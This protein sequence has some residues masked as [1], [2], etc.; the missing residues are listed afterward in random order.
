MSGTATSLAAWAHALTPTD[1]DLRLADRALIDTVAVTVAGRDHPVAEVA[2]QLSEAGRL[3]TVGHVVDFDDLHMESTSHVSVVCVPTALVAGGGARTYL[4][5][6][7]VMARVGTA[8]GWGHYSSGW[9]VTCTAGALGAAA[10]A[11]SA[12]GLGLEGIAT[13]IAL[14]VPGAG[15]VQRAFGTHAKSLQVGF[16]VETGLR[17]AKLAAA[18]ATCDPSAVDA[19]MELVGAADA[20]SM[21]G[22]AVPGGLAIKL[23][24]CCY[25]LQR[26]ISAITSLREQIGA[27][28]EVT[29]IVLSTPESTI[30]PLIHHRPTTGLQA[31]FSLEYAVATALLDDYSGSASFEDAAVRRPEAR[32]IMERVEIRTTPGGGGLLSGELTVEL[33]RSGG[34]IVAGTIADPPGSPNRPPADDQLAAKLAECLR[35]VDAS[36]PRIGWDNARAILLDYLA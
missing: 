16:A 26:P 13:A 24:P 29:R 33:H 10:G 27:P 7:G 3:A 15:G 20:V 1:D 11:A 30:A 14:A 25:A 34:G 2:R 17:A 4:V 12:A 32:D 35:D 22:P 23:Y 19:W 5:A 31:K 21:E 28:S 6:A 9:H 36:P 8:L 18:G